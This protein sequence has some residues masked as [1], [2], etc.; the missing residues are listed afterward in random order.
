MRYAEWESMKLFE[1][2]HN[3][4]QFPFICRAVRGVAQKVMFIK[5][6]ALVTFIDGPFIIGDCDDCSDSVR[7]L[8]IWWFNAGFRR[9]AMI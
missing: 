9:H 4:H 6:I 5:S 7:D 2:I 8:V 1:V 3:L